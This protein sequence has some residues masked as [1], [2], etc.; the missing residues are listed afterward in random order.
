M[1]QAVDKFLA[2]QKTHQK[3]QQL[4]VELELSGD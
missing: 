1:K 3:M 4:E 2:Y